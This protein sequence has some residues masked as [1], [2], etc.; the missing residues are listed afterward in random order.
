MWIDTHCHVE[1]DK[2]TKED[3]ITHAKEAGVSYC[4]VSYCDPKEFFKVKELLSA[5]ES[6]FVT[7]GIHP[8]YVLEAQE[9][10]FLY[11]ERLIKENKRVVAIGE[12][13]LDYYWDKEHKE[14]QR[15]LFRRQMDLAKKLK[16][17][18]VIHTRDA[19]N[20]TY[21]ILKEYPEVHGVLHCF[22]GS[23]EMACKFLDLG[24]LLGI[25][26]VLT[27]KNSKLVEVIERLPL[28]SLVLETD[29]PY[30]APEPK[31]GTINESKNIPY[32]ALKIAECKKVSMEEVAKI[33]TKNA[34]EMFDLPINL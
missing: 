26:G 34:I 27:F 11:L 18:V 31:R 23:Y 9:K 30:L 4:L 7:I 15:T 25:G 20:E 17:P 19:I 24:Y 6:Y 33:T 32:I 10:D 22:S 21:E 12:I 5:S 13:G 8:E 1:E 28:T 3:Y 16:L 2:I 29:S 14:E